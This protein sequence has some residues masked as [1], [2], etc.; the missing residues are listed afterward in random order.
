MELE[1]SSS[2]PEAL[3]DPMGC[4]E[5]SRRLETGAELDEGAILHFWGFSM[6]IKHGI[7]KMADAAL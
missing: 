2:S 6:V 3:F 4:L 1:I 7:A 5:L